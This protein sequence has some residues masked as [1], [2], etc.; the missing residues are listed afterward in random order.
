MF[1]F[2]NNEYYVSHSHLNP[3]AC[4]DCVNPECCQNH[5]DGTCGTI[6]S[7]C[8][9]SRFSCAVEGMKCPEFSHWQYSHNFKTSGGHMCDITQNDMFSRNP[10]CRDT[11]SDYCPDGWCG[12]GIWNINPDADN[13]MKYYCHNDY[14]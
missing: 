11:N 4:L 7:K 3:D 10:E 8:K 14:G 6:G 13:M 2:L 9:N 5:D 12:G 1:S